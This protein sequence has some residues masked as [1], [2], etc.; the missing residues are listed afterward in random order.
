MKINLDT[1]PMLVDFFAICFS[2]SGGSYEHELAARMEYDIGEE[3]SE[4]E[5]A[6]AEI[7]A[8]TMSKDDKWKIIDGKTIGDD[9]D[10]ETIGINAEYDRIIASVSDFDIVERI[11]DTQY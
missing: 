5:V 11:V 9:L 7:A 2:Q 6:R 4:E 8:A 10:E 1:H 3:F